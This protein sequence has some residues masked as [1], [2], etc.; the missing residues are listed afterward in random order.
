MFN[1]GDVGINGFIEQTDLA[2]I[3]LFAAAAKLPALEHSHLMREL[4]DLG[5]AVQ[6]LAVLAGDGLIQAGNLLVEATDCMV[7]IGDLCDQI[8]GEFAQLLCVQTGQ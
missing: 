7:A 3:E 4:V 6:D 5:L 8:T 1:S 2:S